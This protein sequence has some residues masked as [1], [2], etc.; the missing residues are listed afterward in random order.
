M[1][2]GKK[3]IKC[4]GMRGNKTCDITIAINGNQVP[5]SSAS[6]SESVKSTASASSTSVAS[7]RCAGTRICDNVVAQKEGSRI[8][9]KDSPW[10][11]KHPI[12]EASSKSLREYHVAEFCAYWYKGHCCFE[13]LLIY[14]FLLAS[15]RLQAI[16][17]QDYEQCE[18]VLSWQAE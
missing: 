5:G 3:Y 6:F 1:S 14:W 2:I 7:M 11:L 4:L 13:T 10:N 16:R 17:T 12:Y 9:G 15:K 18:L 8:Q